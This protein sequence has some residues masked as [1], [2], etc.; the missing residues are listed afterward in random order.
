VPLVDDHCAD[1]TNRNACVVV[2][3]SFSS[4]GAPGAD[5]A[6]IEAASS[7]IAEVQNHSKTE[8]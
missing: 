3:N 7:D 4:A 5:P 1:E 6:G 8:Q 2:D